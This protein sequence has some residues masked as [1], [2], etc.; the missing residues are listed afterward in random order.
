MEG[1]DIVQCS[2]YLNNYATDPLLMFK[3]L[4]TNKARNK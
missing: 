4:L 2:H 1:S 3:L